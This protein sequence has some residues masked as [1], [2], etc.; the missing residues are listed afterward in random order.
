MSEEKK[1]NRDRDENRDI[2]VCRTSEVLLEGYYPDCTC[3]LT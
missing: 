1:N 2:D 3:F